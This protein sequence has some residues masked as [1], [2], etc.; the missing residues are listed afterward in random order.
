MRYKV[1]VFGIVFFAAILALLEVNKTAQNWI[2]N[3]SD[4]VKI[5]FLNTKD[6]IA[7]VYDK[8]FDQAKQ[9]DI[10]TQKVKNYDQM[11]IELQALRSD[12]VSLQNFVSRSGI[13]YTLPEV[14]LARIISFSSLGERDR[15]WLQA[16]I[17]KFG[18]DALQDKIF[19][20]VKDN[21]TLGVAV[22]QDGRIEGFLNGHPQCNYDVYIGQERAM[23]IVSGS[24]NGMLLVDFIP[25][26]INIKKGDKVFTSGLDGIFLENMPVG[27]VEDVRENYGYLSADVRPY[28]SVDSLSYVWLINRQISQ[29]TILNN[30]EQTE[31]Q[32]E[33]INAL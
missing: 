30:D 32:V 4:Y 25:N 12:I 26:W 19:G 20:I 3:T 23:G 18:N 28:G 24:H 22:V 21:V 13:S 2:L 31:T 11:A 27:V 16:D 10:L 7:Y 29:A 1:L 6:N 33:G 9:I 17:K 5:F 15:V 8:H 14:N